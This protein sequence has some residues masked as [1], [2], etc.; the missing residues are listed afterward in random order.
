MDLPPL[1]RNLT[2][3]VK[4]REGSVRQRLGVVL[5]ALFFWSGIVLPLFY[6]PLI[7]MEPET[8]RETVAVLVLLGIHVLSLVTSHSY[9]PD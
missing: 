2:P 9:N 8:T 7:L 5:Q 4:G 3:A 1:F 6:L